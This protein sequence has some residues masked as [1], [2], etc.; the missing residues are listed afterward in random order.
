MGERIFLFR[1]NC[2]SHDMRTQYTNNIQIYIFWRKWTFFLHGHLYSWPLLLI[3]PRVRRSLSVLLILFP[4]GHIWDQGWPTL[5]T[6]I[7]DN[8]L[9]PAFSHLLTTALMQM[10]HSICNIMAE[11]R[12]IHTDYR[13]QWRKRDG[14]A[15]LSRGEPPPPHPPL[16]WQAFIAFWG[17]L[18]W[19]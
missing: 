5:L 16:P 15:T 6:T 13:V 18:H 2:W 3:M 10:A 8:Y 12:Q 1:N 11:T 14:R 7:G 4:A 17:T 9:K 19:G